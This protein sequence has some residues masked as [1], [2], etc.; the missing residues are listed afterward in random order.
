MFLYLVR[1]IK[2]YEV[3][4]TILFIIFVLC[5]EFF[6]FY[7]PLYVIG[8]KVFHFDKRIGD[9]LLAIILVIITIALSLISYSQI[10]GFLYYLFF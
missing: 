2:Q 8:Y 1:A 3:F 7:S 10:A 5:I 9:N 4:T 6:I